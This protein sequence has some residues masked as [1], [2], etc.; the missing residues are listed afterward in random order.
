VGL[1][2]EM[3]LDFIS[4]LVARKLFWAL[5]PFAL[6]STRRAGCRYDRRRL[7]KV[8]VGLGC[9]AARSMLRPN[10]YSSERFFGSE[11]E[12]VYTIYRLNNIRS[13]RGHFFSS[14][15]TESDIRTVLAPSSFSKLSRL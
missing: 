7:I 6:A 4:F 8:K 3:D 13:P 11:I 9:R 5:I 10:S 2:E 15:R 1:T 12:H 14:G